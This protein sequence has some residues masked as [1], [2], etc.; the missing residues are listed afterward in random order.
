MLH[1]KIT[2]AAITITAD[3]SAAPSSVTPVIVSSAPEAAD[4]L[5]Q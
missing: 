5:A 2:Q 4:A 3:G 1:L